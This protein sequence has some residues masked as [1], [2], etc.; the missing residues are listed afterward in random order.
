MTAWLLFSLTATA[1]GTFA[2]LW[3]GERARRIDAQRLAAGRRPVAARPAMVDGE[4]APKLPPTVDEPPTYPP[5]PLFDE[6]TREKMKHDFMVHYDC[7]EEEAEE[8]VE[9]IAAAT[10]GQAGIA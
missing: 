6:A 10:L 1:A 3:W 7:S 9:E 4:P 8:A 5:E 2:G